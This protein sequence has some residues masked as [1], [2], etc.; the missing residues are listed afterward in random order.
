MSLLKLDD[1]NFKEYPGI[2]IIK[3]L[4]TG[5][6]Y[7]GESLNIKRRMAVHKNAKSNQLIHRSILKNGIDSFQVYCE[8]FPASTKEQLQSMEED[9]IA[10]YD[11]ITPNGYNICINGWRNKCLLYLKKP[12]T[13]QHKLNISNGKRGKPLSEEHKASLS[14]SHTGKIFSEQHKLNMSKSAKGKTFSEPTIEKLRHNYPNKKSV[15]QMTMEG[16]IIKEYFFIREAERMTG[17]SNTKITEVC[18]GKRRKAGNYKW[19]YN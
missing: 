4:I 19:R 7:I 18:K 8:Y 2:Y 14:I 9:M 16:E 17:V 15:I 11:T 13:A 10:M 1:P 12:K 6:E 5:K 3:N